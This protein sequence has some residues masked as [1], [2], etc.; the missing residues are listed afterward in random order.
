MALA[1]AKEWLTPIALDLIARGWSVQRGVPKDTPPADS[2]TPLLRARH[3]LARMVVALR[4]GGDLVVMVQRMRL[5]DEGAPTKVREVEDWKVRLSSTVP[6]SVVI[7][8]AEL[9]AHDPDD[10]RLGQV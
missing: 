2:A 6:P 1:A 8:N 9:A 10:L 4:P 5:V 7:A 3:N